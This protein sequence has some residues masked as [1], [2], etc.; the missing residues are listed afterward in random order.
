MPGRVTAGTGCRHHSQARA[1][2]PS[3]TRG[4]RLETHMHTS[5]AANNMHET[6]EKRVTC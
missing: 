3:M 4:G 5:C 1:H 2:V 6:E